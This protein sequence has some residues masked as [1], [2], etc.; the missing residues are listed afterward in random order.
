MDEG[1][2]CGVVLGVRVEDDGP[3]AC[4]AGCMGVARRGYETSLRGEV[5]SHLLPPATQMINH[6]IS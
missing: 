6:I 5:M 2:K 1:L 4:G 3:A